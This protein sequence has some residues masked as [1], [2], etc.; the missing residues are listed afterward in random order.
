MWYCDICEKEM[1]INTSWKHSNFNT[2]IHRTECGISVKKYDVNKQPEIYELDYILRDVIKEC[3]ETFFDTYVYRFMH[4]IK[5]T[6]TVNNE[7][8]FL[9]I[10]SE[11]TNFKSK[12]SGSIRNRKI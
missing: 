5:F 10:I 9:T 7:V 12:F 8:F 2:H 4:E 3:S 6:N 11:F 1:A